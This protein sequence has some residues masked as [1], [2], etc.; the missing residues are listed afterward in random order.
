LLGEHAPDHGKTMPTA[1]QVIDAL[2]V[3]QDPDLHKDLVTL[4][5]I[6]EVTVAD[7]LARFALVLTTGACPVKQ[8][9]EDQCRA[10]ALGVDGIVRVEITVSA[11]VPK[12]AMGATLPGVRHIIGVGSGKGGVGKSTVTVNLACVLAQSGARVGLLDADIYGPSVPT[13]MG[14]KGQPQ[15]ETVENSSGGASRKMVP[16]VAHG[17]KLM[18]MGFIISDQEAVVWRG[19]MAQGALKQFLTDV[20]W[21]DLDYLLVDLPPGTGDIQ[22]TLASAVPLAGTV[23]VSTPQAVALLD[24][25]R[26]VAMFRKVSA[27]VFGIVENMSGF[28]CP[29]CGHHEPIFGAGGAAEEAAALDL[30]FL[31]AIPLEPGV[32]AAGDDGVPVVISHP[33]SLSAKALTAVAQRVAAR[34]SVAAMSAAPR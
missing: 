3:V 31:G 20:A 28:V 16:L 23:I 29:K 5:M 14:V 6:R 1:E 32:R 19:P 13:M 8:Q 34:A 30:P 24:A 33:E 18:S 27:P 4:N 21:G 25:R 17:V 12:G 10:A 2:R 11:E 7:G 15:I 9:L 22:M 26:S